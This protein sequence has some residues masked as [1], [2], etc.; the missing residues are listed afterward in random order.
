M[1]KAQISGR[2]IYSGTRDVAGAS[3]NSET[4]CLKKLMMMPTLHRECYSTLL[5]KKGDVGMAKCF[6]KKYGNKYELSTTC[7]P[8][9]IKMPVSA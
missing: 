3:V 2:I 5:N 7:N 8:K 1:I 4:T 6:S 9:V